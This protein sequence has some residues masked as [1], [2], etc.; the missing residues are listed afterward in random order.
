MNEEI[1]KEVKKE[2][3][4]RKGTIQKYFANPKKCLL[5]ISRSTNKFHKN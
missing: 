4:S 3:G 5:D 1:R 2:Y